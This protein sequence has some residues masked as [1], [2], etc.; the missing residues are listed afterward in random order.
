M[1]DPYA[2][3]ALAADRRKTF[4]AEAEEHQLRRQARSAAPKVKTSPQ[5]WLLRIGAWLGPGLETLT[6]R[7]QAH[8]M[9]AAITREAAG[10]L[11]RPID[12]SDSE[13][14]CE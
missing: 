1:T 4:M 3:L 13:L 12:A 7:P 14:L 11:I 8:E 5:R 10:V 2:H 6:S 9:P